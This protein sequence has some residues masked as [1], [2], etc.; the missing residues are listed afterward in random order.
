MSVEITSCVGHGLVTTS[1]CTRS[2]KLGSLVGYSSRREVSVVLVPY[3]SDVLKQLPCVRRTPPGQWTE[4]TG[5]G[6]GHTG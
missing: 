1:Q 3:L 4:F 6:S 5:T 2:R